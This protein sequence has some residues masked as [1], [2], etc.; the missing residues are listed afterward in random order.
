MILQLSSYHLSGGAGVAATRLHRAL[1]KHGVFARLLVDQL[2]SQEEGVVGISASPALKRK[3]WIR[4]AAER[5]YFFPYERDRSVRFAF[6]PARIGVDLSNH[7]LVKQAEV[8]HLNWVNFGFQ[9]IHTLEKLLELGKPVVWTLHDMWT[10]TGGCHYSRGCDNFSTHCQYCSFLRKPDR[11]DL[12]FQ[13]FEQKKRLFERYPITLV[14]PSEWLADLARQSTLAKNMRVEVIPYAIDSTVFKPHDKMETRNKL[15]LPSG[16]K[17]VLFGSANIRDPRKGFSY[18]R[19]ALEVVK[20]LDLEIVTFGKSAPEAFD[21]LGVPFHN[22]GILD[23]ETKIAAAYSA[24]DVMVVPSLEDNLP[25]TVMESM[26]CGTPVV[27]FRT[28]GIP[29]MIDHEINGFVAEL[30]SADALAEG[31]RWVL[32]HN[33]DGRISTKSRAK[34]VAS[35]AESVI[36]ARYKELYKSHF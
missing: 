26:S 28:G 6:S 33:N 31:I 29:D 34:V 14:C 24:A 27:G 5:L 32:Q 25:N 8:I 22:L 10:F 1:N 17:L 2:S 4:F 18:L 36:A 35:Y 20:D 12:S 7:P 23:S 3:Y 16:K 19:E 11:Y 9:S 15:G 30:K 21:G 13:I